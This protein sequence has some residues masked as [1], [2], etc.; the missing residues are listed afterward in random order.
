MV[1]FKTTK[2]EQ[3]LPAE[4]HPYTVALGSC[5]KLSEHYGNNNIDSTTK[6]R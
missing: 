3:V 4:S 6:I 2:S 1:Y 5:S